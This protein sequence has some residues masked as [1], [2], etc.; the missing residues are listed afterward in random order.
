VV[1]ALLNGDRVAV[2]E[3]ASRLV[4]T[5]G[6]S[7]ATVVADLLQPALH[8][9]GDL[10][11]R[12]VIGVA[13]EH[14]AT[15]IVESVLE[16]LPPT[17]SGNP[18]PPGSRCLLTSVGTEQHRLG[19]RALALTLEDDGWSVDHMSSPLPLP[20]LLR[21]VRDRRPQVVGL[22]AGYLPS[23]RHIR[24]AIGELRREGPRVLV[25][26]A[27][28]TRVPLLWKRLGADAHAGDARM[29]AVLMRRLLRA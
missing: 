21:W 9:I 3:S 12:G 18:V 29:A 8:Q 1:D 14:R 5:E 13:E 7:R 11:Y 2:R 17:P 27:A 6:S 10:W 4:T 15:A 23:L 16:G 25:G 26:G 24:L 19:L 22:S 20:E 28:F